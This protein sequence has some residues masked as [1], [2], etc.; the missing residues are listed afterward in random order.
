[1]L[2]P[3]PQF[4]FGILRRLLFTRRP[5][6]LSVDTIFL[7]VVFESSFSLPVWGSLIIAPPPPPHLLNGR[8][9]CFPSALQS[10]WSYFFLALT[11]FSSTSLNLGFLSRSSLGPPFGFHRHS[12]VS[13]HS[14]RAF[15][16]FCFVY[17]RSFFH[18][19]LAGSLSLTGK[20]RPYVRS[21]TPMRRLEQ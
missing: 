8:G 3:S 12:D 10:S 20:C 5:I 19:T 14:P 7:R 13:P 18:V 15:P 21:L 16:F 2:V 4:V 9:A 11:K 17:A 6:I 1:L